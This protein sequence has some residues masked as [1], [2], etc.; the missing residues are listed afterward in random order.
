MV[1]AQT[2]TNYP[3]VGLNY[4]LVGLLNR[5]TGDVFYSRTYGHSTMAIAY[6]GQASTN[7]HVAGR[8]ETGLSDLVVVVNGLASA[9]VTIN[10]R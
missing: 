1:D 2:A 6:A 8:T 10:V 5:V 7:F 4:P 3:L 9:P